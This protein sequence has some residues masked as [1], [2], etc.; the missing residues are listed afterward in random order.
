M[1][2]LTAGNSQAETVT[3]ELLNGDSITGTIVEELSNN[4]EKVLDH[5]QLG[6]LTILTSSLKSKQTAPAWRTSM[7]AGLI[8]NEKDGDSS[9]STTIS[10]ESKYKK[11]GNNLLLKAGLNTSQSRD[12]GEP[13]EIETQKGMAEVRY[14]YNMPSGLG[15]FALTDYN[16]DGK[17]DSGVNSL[18]TGIGLAKQVIQNETTEL[19]V[20]LG[21]S[22]Q[23][24]N[25]GNECGK[26]S[27]CGNAYAGATFTTDLSWQPSKMF[28]LEFNNKFSSAFTPD[29]KPANN[30]KA[31]FKF[32]PSIYSGL[33]TSLQYNLIYQSMSTPE[34]NNSA[35]LQLGADF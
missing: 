31:K 19:V 29:I 35:S 17:N 21:P 24:T 12:N 3:L 10:V 5:P 13:I 32:Y 20:A 25:S 30:F 27:Y 6:R 28:K 2:L 26:D 4:Q 14:D 11:G 1:L 33:F 9:L 15:L 16:Y 7:T 34:V 8:G 23:W 18:L 22:M